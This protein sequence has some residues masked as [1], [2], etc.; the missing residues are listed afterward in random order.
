M[1]WVRRLEQGFEISLLPPSEQSRF[2]IKFSVE[3]L[4]RED[5]KTRMEGYAI[6]RQ[7]GG[8]LGKT[9]AE[10]RKI[11]QKDVPVE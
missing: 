10:W 7:N 5:Y 1:P 8:A 2:I 3:G 9:N 6:G 4:L 11:D